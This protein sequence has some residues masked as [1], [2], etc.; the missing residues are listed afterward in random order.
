MLVPHFTEV[1]HNMNIGVKINKITGIKFIMCSYDISHNGLA[2]Y[3]V[4]NWT[5]I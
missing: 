5:M 3:K 2:F 1:A 4:N